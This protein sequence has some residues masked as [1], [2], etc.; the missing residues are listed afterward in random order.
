MRQ[1]TNPN[2][3][4][5]YLPPDTVQQKRRL[6]IQIAPTDG[7]YEVSY[8]TCGDGRFEQHRHFTRI[9]FTRPKT[10]GTACA[11]GRADAGSLLQIRR[12][13]RRTVPVIA[14]HGLILARND[15]AT[16]TVARGGVTAHEPEAV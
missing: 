7:T 1:F 14:L 10:L 9:N 11:R 6:S 12:I 13:A 15:G 5:K 2:V 3:R 16:D 8:Q 4:R